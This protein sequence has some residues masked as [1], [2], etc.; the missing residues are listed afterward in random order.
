MPARRESAHLDCKLRAAS[1]GAAVFVTAIG[2]PWVP[3][4]WDCVETPWGCVCVSGAIIA[5]RRPEPPVS[6]W[7]KAA[8]NPRSTFA[9][10]LGERMV[11]TAAANPACLILWFCAGRAQLVDQAIEPGG[12]NVDG[13]AQQEGN[14][15]WWQG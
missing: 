13:I 3:R 4:S 9:R 1:R 5:Q 2:Q 15:E 7:Q 6:R 11:V 14:Q 8:A 10:R 12:E